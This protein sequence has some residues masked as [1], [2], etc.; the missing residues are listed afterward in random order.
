V[1]DEEGNFLRDYTF[2][3]PT[4][5]PCASHR[6][7]K[8]INVKHRLHVGYEIFGV[9]R[10][11]Q[12]AE[13]PLEKADAH[14]D[15][16]LLVRMTLRG[17]FH[18]VPESLFMSRSHSNQSM[19][20]KGERGHLSRIIGAGPR[21][22]AE[23]WDPAKKGKIVFPEWR[24]L[25]EYWAAIGEVETLSAGD[26][27]RSRLWVFAWVIRNWGK[28]ARDIVLAA[29]HGI[30]RRSSMNAR[31]PNAPRGPSASGG[32]DRPALLRG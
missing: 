30:S 9:W 14:G 7:G 29:E 13:T 21:P 18:E 27:I 23:W 12:L 1:L 4:N 17:R 20:S 3:V 2:R 25:A 6:F 16:I 26:R 8:L 32:R 11:A 5:S 19:Q 22:P 10:R 28:L 15:R 24:L 31:T